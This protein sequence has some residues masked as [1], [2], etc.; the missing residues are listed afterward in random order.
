MHKT[1]LLGIVAAAL[2]IGALVWIFA[3]RE[4]TPHSSV[5]IT[6]FDECVEAGYPVME[7]YPAQCR[8][9]E[10]E[11]FTQDIGN[12][13]EYADQIRVASPRPGDVIASPLMVTGEAV[14]GWYFEASFPVKLVDANG[15]V[16][17]EHY[18]QAQGEWMTSNF[19]P[20]IS[21][22]NFATPTTESGTLIINNDNP[23]GLPENS[24]ELRI[25]IRFNQ[26]QQTMNVSVFWGSPD[27]S[28]NE[29]TSAVSVSRSVPKSD[30]VA[31]AALTELL[32]GP[33]QSEKNQGY[34]TS[35]PQNAG[36]TINGLRIENKTAY[37]DFNDELE[38]NVAGSCRVTHIRTQIEKTLKQFATVENVVISID[39][40]TDD[41]LQP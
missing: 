31:R 12:E 24:R 40:R 26:A 16:L 4:T 28:G 32:K 41:I 11:T 5:M 37:V 21:T 30:G 29:C 34:T 7:S 6:S 8:T 19:V 35:I 33:T 20:F 36:V 39:G 3:L 10:G 38:N 2:V 23:S 14:G 25:P 15:M 9:P 17:V 18:A 22:L 27:D 1:L 13:M